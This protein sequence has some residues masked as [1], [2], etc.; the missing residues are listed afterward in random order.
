VPKGSGQNPASDFKVILKQR[1]E[2][3]GG[4]RIYFYI[5]ASEPD[6]DKSFNLQWNGNNRNKKEEQKKKGGGEQ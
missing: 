5:R 3:K 2:K 6:V 4:A 1:A